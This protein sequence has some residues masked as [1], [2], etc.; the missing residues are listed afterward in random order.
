MR[1]LGAILA[2]GR[3]R[4]FGSDKAAAAVDGVA[5]LDR[6]ARVLAIEC[7][8]VV[9]IGRD[10]PGLARV[11]DRP[12]PGLGPLGGL[13]GALAYARDHGFDA[14]LSSAC[15]VP[16]LPPGL[17]ALLGP[18]DALL[19]DQPTIGLW[20]A[21]QADALLDWMAANERH[22]IRAW[23]DHARARRVDYAAIANINTL[24]ELAAYQAG[25]PPSL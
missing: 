12:R 20:R 4:R 24:E 11:E 1:L 13:A 17:A 9:V 10:W 22:A 14:V 21:A 23:A 2:G 3:S 6:V 19:A 18:A 15:D 8:A 25:L 7:E 5:M 16:A